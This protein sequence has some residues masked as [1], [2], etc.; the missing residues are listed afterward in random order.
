MKNGITDPIETILKWLFLLLYMMTRFHIRNVNNASF[1]CLIYGSCHGGVTLLPFW[2]HSLEP[3]SESLITVWNT[4]ADVWKYRA[5]AC[6]CVRYYRG[7]LG[8]NRNTASDSHRHTQH[9]ATY[10][11]SAPQNRIKKNSF[12]PDSI[13]VKWGS[14]ITA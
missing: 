14:V 11:K 9:M 5:C 1:H 2:E 13:N 12:L 4:N 8:E 3:T 10:D 7:K 6:V